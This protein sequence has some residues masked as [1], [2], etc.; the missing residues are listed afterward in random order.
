MSSLGQTDITPSTPNLPSGCD[1]IG[2][3][4]CQTALYGPTA[5]NLVREC[6]PVT[7]AVH[8]QYVIGSNDPN[9][10]IANVSAASGDI[11]SYNGPTGAVDDALSPIPIGTPI[12]TNG[13]PTYVYPQRGVTPAPPAAASPATTTAVTSAAV[14]AA[15]TSAP[16]D[17]SPVPVSTDSLSSWLSQTLLDGIPN[18]AL[19]AGGGL[20]LLIFMGGKR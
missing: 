3:N 11:V 7:D 1:V 9:A 12:E 13:Q 16:L 15:S 2:D 18:W 20:L 4:L 17:L 8:Y 5:C 19:V 14:T 10:D 6:D